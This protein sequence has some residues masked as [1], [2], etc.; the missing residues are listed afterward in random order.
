MSK[1]QNNIKEFVAHV[2]KLVGTVGPMADAFHRLHMQ[3]VKMIEERVLQSPDEAD[4][5]L[6]AFRKLLVHH[7][8]QVRWRSAFI[9]G[10]L[11][12]NYPASQEIA[13]TTKTLISCVKDPAY[14]EPVNTVGREVINALGRSN[15]VEGEDVLI[16]LVNA[17]NISS[18]R[19]NLLVTLGKIG[20]L[21]TVVELDKLLSNRSLR[22]AD[23]IYISWALGRIGSVESNHHEG[24]PLP[25]KLLEAPLEKL[26]RILDSPVRH[27]DV[28]YLT[29]YAVG[30]ICDQRDAHSLNDSISN[31][32]LKKAETITTSIEVRRSEILLS[33]KQNKK[34]KE[35]AEIHVDRLVEISKVLT[36]RMIHGQTLD[37]KGERILLDARILLEAKTLES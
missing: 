15:R 1:I 12:Q 6:I 30:E 19:T 5:Y 33:L 35:R 24:F 28:H 26:L 21:K 22:E 2:E 8:S 20:G 34:F 32:L 9:I 29:V 16:P 31:S 10:K 36:L 14:F 27:P 4:A 11:M 3:E 13:R 23:Q 25:R 18:I 37:P 7:N 17:N